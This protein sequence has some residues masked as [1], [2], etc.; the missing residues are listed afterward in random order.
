MRREF[1]VKVK[2]AAYERAGG[3]CEHCTAP[4]RGG[5]HYDHRIPDALGGEPVLS[6]VQVLC[7]TC[8]GLKTSQ[9]DVPTIAKSKRTHAKHI[10]AREKRGWRRSPYTRG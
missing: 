4:I 7:R 8:H 2:V 6:N 9:Q 5:A 3:C 10:S 1:P